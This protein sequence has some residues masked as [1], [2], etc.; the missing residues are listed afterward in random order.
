MILGMVL[1]YVL[2][3]HDP[4]SDRRSIALRADMLKQ[5]ADNLLSAHRRDKV[6]PSELEKLYKNFPSTCSNGLSVK[7]EEFMQLFQRDLIMYWYAPLKVTK[8][9]EFEDSIRFA[10]YGTF[11]NVRD[12]YKLCFSED[13]RMLEL[14]SVI[15]FGLAGGVQ[16]H[17]QEFRSIQ[18]SLA[19]EDH[20]DVSK[21]DL[22]GAFY[23]ELTFSLDDQRMRLYRVSDMILKRIMPKS[24]YSSPSMRSIVTELFATSV[25]EPLLNLIIDPVAV[26]NLISTL[27]S[28]LLADKIHHDFD[29]SNFTHQLTELD[30]PE[31]LTEIL[32]GPQFDDFSEYLEHIYAPK[33]LRFWTNVD[34]FKRFSSGFETNDRYSILSIKQD[35]KSIFNMHFTTGAEFPIPLMTET[36]MTTQY[37]HL[38]NNDESPREASKRIHREFVQDLAKVIESRPSFNCFDESVKRVFE[39]LLLEHIDRYHGDYQKYKKNL[40]SKRNSALTK[41]ESSLEK[42]DI[43]NGVQIEPEPSEIDGGPSDGN[44][45]LNHL[46]SALS[47]LREQHMLISANIENTAA[48]LAQQPALSLPFNIANNMETQSALSQMLSTQQDLQAQIDQLYGMVKEIEKENS[49]EGES[50]R[51]TVTMPS[52]YLNLSGLEVHIMDMSSGEAKAPLGIKSFVD[53]SFAAAKQTRLRNTVFMIQV[54]KTYGGSGWVLYKRFSDLQKLDV[55][56]KQQFAKVSKIKFPSMKSQSINILNINQD[57]ESESISLLCTELEGYLRMLLVDQLLCESKPMQEFFKPDLDESVLKESAKSDRS[58][59]KI[60]PELRKRITDVLKSIRRPSFNLMPPS[61]AVDGESVNISTLD[62]SENN[63]TSAEMQIIH[64]PEEVIPKEFPMI[65]PQDEACEPE[66]P[67][68]PKTAADFEG[69]ATV[70]VDLLI[71]TS[72]SLLTEIFELHAPTQWVRRKALG[73]LRQIIL[74]QSKTGYMYSMVATNIR[75]QIRSGLDSIFCENTI[76]NLFDKVLDS[77]WP[78]PSREWFKQVTPTTEEQKAQREQ[79]FEQARQALVKFM[80]GTWIH[81]QPRSDPSEIS[82][83]RTNSTATLGTGDIS[84]EPPGTQDSLQQVVIFLH[85]L[86]GKQNVMNGSMRLLKML[87]YPQLNRIL[88]MNMLET[89]ARAIFNSI[90]DK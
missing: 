7:I 73:A 84:A 41:A 70:D 39:I 85:R 68:R 47:S 26:N 61:T 19:V 63:I 77:L 66:S 53:F 24:E 9:A 82:T 18:K 74:Q 14:V 50:G 46:V 42:T 65:Q 11:S 3:T 4:Y 64:D 48:K 1:G 22:N 27:F 34:F 37:H 87:Q 76:I 56:L 21:L 69:G 52:N 75:D 55:D 83:T 81:Q 89:L 33:Y 79:S 36:L 40:S 51:S 57:T 25:L 6:E 28:D 58:P 54:E 2:A 38:K 31:G 59:K 45:V 67:K 10:L 71:D 90:S 13:E 8:S 80:S 88:I 5:F 86:A 23:S 17:L 78:P 44:E 20:I 49:D 43:I 72:Y 32:Q 35:A 30:I 29:E 62:I 60:A 16:L 12:H 15:F